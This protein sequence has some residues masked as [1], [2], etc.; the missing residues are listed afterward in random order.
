M[1]KSDISNR[2]VSRILEIK[3]G[4]PSAPY[5]ATDIAPRNSNTWNFC[6]S[7]L[8]AKGRVW[9]RLEYKVEM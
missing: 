3:Q 7:K 2:W 1:P 9:E 8:G 6:Y 4:L 5:T